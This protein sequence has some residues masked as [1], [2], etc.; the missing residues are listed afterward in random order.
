MVPAQAAKRPRAQCDCECAHSGSSTSC[1]SAGSAAET[2]S[3]SLG[4]RSSSRSASHVVRAGANAAQ[5]PLARGCQQQAD[6]ATVVGRADSL[7]E[8]RPLE[9]IDMTRQRRWRDPLELGQ[10]P[11]AQSRAA[12]DQPQERRLPGG[13]AETLG[14]TAKLA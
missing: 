5:E 12:T 1:R 3:S 11:Q 7:D 8:P 9:P 14:L 4:S 13:D 10:V 2:A 6:P